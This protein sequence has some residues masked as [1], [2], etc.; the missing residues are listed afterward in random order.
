MCVARQTK[1]CD[2]VVAKTNSTAAILQCRYLP[3]FLVPLEVRRACVVENPAGTI[4]LSTIRCIRYSVN[5]F[6]SVHLTACQSYL[7]DADVKSHS[8][9]MFIQTI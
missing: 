5:V 6:K 3:H 2:L 8:R 1:I 7:H 4:H 9:F